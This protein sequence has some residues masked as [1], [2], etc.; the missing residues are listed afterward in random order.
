MMQTANSGA[1]HQ[2]VFARAVHRK[3]SAISEA[4]WP[5]EPNELA[6]LVDLGMADNLIAAYFGVAP[7]L[8]VALRDRYGL[9]D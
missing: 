8:V 9:H 2:K 4:H 6:A 5:I 3:R 1:R 7:S